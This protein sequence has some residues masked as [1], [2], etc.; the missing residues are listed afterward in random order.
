MIVWLNIHKLIN[1]IYHVNRM[2]DKNHMI[3]SLDAEGAA[4]KIF[5]MVKTEKL[6]IEGTSST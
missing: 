3:T 5:F 6:S 2:K 1:I 4:D